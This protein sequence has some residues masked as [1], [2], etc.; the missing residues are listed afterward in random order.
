[1]HFK[2]RKHFNA[3]T[4]LAVIA[5][6]LATTGGAYAASRVVITSITQIKPSVRAA[7]RGNAG[8]AGKTGVAGAPGAIGATGPQGPQGNAGS[9][10]STGST[11][12]NGGAGKS[13]V[14][15]TFEASKEPAGEPCKKAGGSSFEV[16]GSG[17]KSYVCNGSGTSETLAPGKSEVGAW[18]VTATKE[19]DEGVVKAF[20]AVSFPVPLEAGLSKEHVFF[21][22]NPGTE[23]ETECPGTAAKPEAAPGD[24]CAYSSNP[25]TNPINSGKP[26]LVPSGGVGPGTAGTGTAGAIIQLEP[27][28][29]EV[30]TAVGTWAVTAPTG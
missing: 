9:T 20:T 16:E 8:P 2:I 11:G 13:V 27:Q 19:E 30:A 17:K 29:E 26:I 18:S 21:I 6:L 10:G 24:F 5:I 23:H 14:S 4:V 22:E 28:A 12:S 1:M 15:S 25:L 7:L 3:T